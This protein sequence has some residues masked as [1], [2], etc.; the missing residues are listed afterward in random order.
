MPN[1]PSR[2]SL[3]TA[4]GL[5]VVGGLGAPGGAARAA[6]ASAFASP[7]LTPYVDELPLPPVLTGD[8]TL[9]MAPSTHRFHRDLGLAPTWSYGGQPY[10]GPTIEARRGEPLVL[11]FHNALGD[12]L[13]AADV[14]PDLMG[15]SELDRTQPRTAV[16]L[17]GAITPPEADGHPEDTFR[18]G[19]TMTYRHP[20]GQQAAQLWYHDHAMGITRLNSVAGLAGQYLLRDA[21]DTGAA[22]NPL[23]LPAGEFELP[24]TLADRRF[25]PDGSLNFRTSPAVPQGR[26]DGGMFGDAMTVNGV[27]SPYA[28]VARGLYRLRLLNASNARGY[29]LSFSDRMP[30]WVVG[31]DGGLLDAPVR[32][33][34]VRLAPGE[35]LDLVVDFG[36]LAAG[37]HVDLGNDQQESPEVVAATGVTPVTDVMR[38]VGTGAP[39]FAAPPPPL[40]R[41]GAREPAP[42]SALPL[43]YG[44]RRVVT[45]TP[46]LGPGYPPAGMMMNNVMYGDAPIVAPRQGTT[47]LWEFVNLSPQAHP[48]H[49]H[50]VHMRIV[51]RQHLDVQ[52]YLRANPRP[53]AG[54]AWTPSP[55]PYL[56]GAARPPEA[57]EA[58]AKDTVACPPG[59]VTRV[60]A[61]FPDA[62]ELG[63][64]PDAAF[65]AL[66]GGRLQGYVWHCHLLDHEDDC[67]MARYRVTV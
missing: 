20:N 25:H 14:D 4:A 15:A 32:T 50:L 31:T 44:R 55:D 59:T 6:E 16:H 62:A 47:E 60:L 49:L 61:R 13:F 1:G 54:T 27:V 7:R 34:S 45:I 29:R 51:A 19:G 41:G 67:M 63:F 24:L 8:R 2:R 35:R 53:P 10:H 48:M 28:K 52:A 66:G 11:T 9:V 3:L 30:F 38:F 5:G 46:P 22:G 58:G 37:E 36:S 21:Y 40:L 12:H 57:W 64:D 26:W 33:T 42:L 18:P 39:G 56:V 23:G 43:S 17:H 65:T